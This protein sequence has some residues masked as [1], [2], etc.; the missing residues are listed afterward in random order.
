MPPNFIFENGGREEK[1][2]KMLMF[3]KRQLAKTQHRSSHRAARMHP[4]SSRSESGRFRTKAFL[5]FV[6]LI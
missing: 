3:L 2:N 6:Y 1:L 5:C 4:K